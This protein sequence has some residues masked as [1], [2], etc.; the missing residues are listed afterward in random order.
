[1]LPGDAAPGDRT[2]KGKS[3]AVF[4]LAS[5]NVSYSKWKLD[6][7]DTSRG[8]EGDDREGVMGSL[9]S[10]ILA[11]KGGII[12]Q[13]SGDTPAGPSA[14]AGDAVPHVLLAP[15]LSVAQFLIMAGSRLRVWRSLR[16]VMALDAGEEQGNTLLRSP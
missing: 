12:A 6:D 8:M 13:R 7:G 14:A 10:G 15:S 2:R 16:L 5:F 3:A 11:R 9:M 1:M 4:L